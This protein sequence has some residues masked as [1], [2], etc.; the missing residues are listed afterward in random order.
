MKHLWHTY[1]YS[2][3]EY[4][5]LHREWCVMLFLFMKIWGNRV[6]DQKTRGIHPEIF[7]FTCYG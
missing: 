5:Q 1:V 6:V 3:D 2:M 7:A 4:V